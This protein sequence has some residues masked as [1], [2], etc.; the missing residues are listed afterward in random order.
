[1]RT[2]SRES[3][4]RF[5]PTRGSVQVHDE[6]AAFPPV[7]NL[8]ASGH[9]DV[10][11]PSMIREGRIIARMHVDMRGGDTATRAAHVIVM[12]KRFGVVLA[13]NMMLDPSTRNPR[14]GWRACN[15]TCTTDAAEARHPRSGRRHHR[16]LPDREHVG[17]TPVHEPGR[18]GRIGTANNAQHRG[19]QILETLRERLCLTRKSRAHLPSG[20]SKSPRR[21][22]TSRRR[23]SSPMKSRVARSSPAVPYSLS[24]SR[25]SRSISSLLSMTRSPI[26]HALPAGMTTDTIR[27]PPALSDKPHARPTL[28]EPRANDNPPH[29]QPRRRPSP[30]P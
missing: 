3:R 27:S 29:A 11:H 9:R 21:S 13:R 26:R 15:G 19:Q 4:A 28:S 7:M 8:N 22:K 12:H 24:I 14:R 20:K 5:P 18:R 23:R 1:M 17:H 16:P 25:R 10:A 6:C 30:C 2:G